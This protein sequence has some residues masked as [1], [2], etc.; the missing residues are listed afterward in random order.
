M[1]HT[2]PP[3]ELPKDTRKGKKRSSEYR[4]ELSEAYAGNTNFQREICWLMEQ[5]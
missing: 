5:V 1:L 3:S 2:K 4:I